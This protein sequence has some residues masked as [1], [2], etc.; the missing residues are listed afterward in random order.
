MTKEII[1]TP[2][3]KSSFFLIIIILVMEACSQKPKNI[4]WKVG[5]EWLK[6]GQFKRLSKWTD[7]IQENSAKFDD[8]WMK[9]DSFKQIAKRV[10]LDFRYSE[11]EINKQLLESLGQYSIDDK[12][13][14]EDN[15]LL[16]YRIING[17][18]RYFSRAVS[19]LLRLNKESVDTVIESARDIFCRKHTL[20]V[21]NQ[22]DSVGK[23]VMPV[24]F[25]ISYKINLEADAVPAGETIRCWMPWPKENHQR[26]FDLKL[27]NTSESKY[28]IAPDSCGQRSIYM[29][30]KAQADRETVFEVAFSYRSSA[31]YFDPDEMKLEPYKRES[32]LFLKYTGEEWPH[33][34]FSNRIKNLTDS[35][36]GKETEPFNVVRK[37]YYWIDENIPW[38]GALEYSTIPNIPE[39]ALDNMKGD[40]GIQTLLF[41]TMARYKGIPVKWQSGWMMHPGEI[42]LHDWCEVYYEGVGWIPL[43]MSFGLQKS[44]NI[45]LKEF[46]ISG[47]DSYRMIVNDAIG[48]EFY[49]DKKFLRSEPLDFQRGEL[50]WSGGNIYFNKWG[51]DLMVKDPQ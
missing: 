4:N 14:W 10:E 13:K 31:R 11:D 12:K 41:M 7:S 44:E 24:D 47:I 49:P 42:N 37:I 26:Q 3:I 40:C 33:I 39:Y 32:E 15:K 17:E 34:R 22:T 50:E 43:D 25:E 27:I 38:A 23:C 35:I 28:I 21:I 1:V 16:E 6:E 36:V 20:K 51:Y 30:K 45:K 2:L 19:N 29:E 18:K 8:V 48:S 5:E 9:A 46:Y